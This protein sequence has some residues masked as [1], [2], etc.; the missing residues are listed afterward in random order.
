[1]QQKIETRGRMLRKLI[2]TH[3]QLKTISFKLFPMS[4]VTSYGLFNNP[5]CVS[6][7]QGGTVVRAWVLSFSNPCI[8]LIAAVCYLKIKYSLIEK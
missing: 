8:P 4:Q 2:T 1:M 3:P 7:V 5:C 6:A